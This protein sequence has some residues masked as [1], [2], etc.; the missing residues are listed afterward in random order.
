M[1]Q[2]EA[3]RD[4]RQRCWSASLQ[5]PSDSER[6]GIGAALKVLPA[7]ALGGRIVQAV[8]AANR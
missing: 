7:G 3:W 2:A 4:T 1:S 8:A 5:R 6:L